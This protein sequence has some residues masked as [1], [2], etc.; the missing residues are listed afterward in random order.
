MGERFTVGLVGVVGV[1]GAA[2]W[3]GEVHVF[4][5]GEFVDE[6]IR[7]GWFELVDED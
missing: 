2:G 5:F 3:D 4:E 6:V 7:V 1:A